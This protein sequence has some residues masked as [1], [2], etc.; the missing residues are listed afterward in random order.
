MNIIKAHP[1]VRSVH[2]KYLL[3]SKRRRLF[4]LIGHNFNFEIY[5]M[6][7]S[8]MN[9]TAL[10]YLLHYVAHSYL[11]F[12]YSPVETLKINNSQQMLNFFSVIWLVFSSLKKL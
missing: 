11:R 7:V 5:L 4:Y 2:L 1:K 6:N 8:S 3:V 9:V 10:F 12:S